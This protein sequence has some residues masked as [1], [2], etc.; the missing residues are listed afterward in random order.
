[1]ATL[2]AIDFARELASAAGIRSIAP[3]DRLKSLVGE[4]R[5][6]LAWHLARMDAFRS[7]NDIP[8]LEQEQQLLYRYMEG[9][10]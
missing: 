3:L 4:R 8:A 5:L 2:L 7:L 1:R 10:Q 6:R 9:K